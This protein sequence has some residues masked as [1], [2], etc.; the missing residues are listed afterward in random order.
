[1]GIQALGPSGFRFNTC[2]DL[3]FIA[4]IAFSISVRVKTLASASGGP[5]PR[6]A[7]HVSALKGPSAA[8]GV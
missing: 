8:P 1:M 3:G 6:S 4:L 2:S 5:A 7:A